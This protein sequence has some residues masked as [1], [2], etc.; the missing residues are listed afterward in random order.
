M[1]TRAGDLRDRVGFYQRE[2]LGDD[3]PDSA[4]P[5]YGNTV[6][7][8]PAQ[9]E[10]IVAAQ[11]RPRLGGEQMLAGRLEGKNVVNIV[12]RQSAATAAI[13]TEWRAK[14]ERTGEIFNIRSKI[15]PDQGKAG[16][17]AWWELLCEKGV[18]T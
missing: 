13:T 7:D 12:V 15:D 14:D 3:S 5:D 10:L 11:I 9:A 16:Q 8:F 17:G 6:G 1:P 18:G 2:V 4:S